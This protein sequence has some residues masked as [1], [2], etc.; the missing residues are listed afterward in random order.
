MPSWMVVA[1]TIVIVLIL[2]GLTDRAERPTSPARTGWLPYRKR[3]WLFSVAERSFY[4]VLERAA[5][6]DFRVFAKVRLGDLVWMPSRTRSR[7][8]HWRRISQ[9]HVDFLLCDLRNVGPVLVIE[10]DDASHR[11]FD[12]QERDRFVDSI[13]ESIGLPIWHVPV[14]S[15]Y[16]LA[17][18]AQEIRERATPT[19]GAP[20]ARAAS[21]IR[22]S[23]PQPQPQPQAQ[24][25]PEPSGVLAGAGTGL[26]ST[27]RT[28]RG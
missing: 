17:D 13:M 20:R 23:L 4:D 10:L 27:P 24:P 25:Q 18:V 3:D 19:S 7:E 11:Q 5:G 16:V 14:K 15:G 9:K 26:Q 6:K 2:L 8:Y 21:A 28:Q 12:R 1:A 22:S